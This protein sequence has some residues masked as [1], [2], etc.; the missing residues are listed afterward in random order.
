MSQVEELDAEASRAYEAC[1]WA[2]ESQFANCKIWRTA[3][4][5]V[6]VAAAVIA[7]VAGV[8]GLAQLVSAQ[9]AGAIAIAAFPADLAAN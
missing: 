5:I 8:A 9:V 7:A 6:G 4:L 1:L 2:S 3:D